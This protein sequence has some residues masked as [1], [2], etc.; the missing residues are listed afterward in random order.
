VFLIG[1]A[2]DCDLV[3]GDATFPEAYAYLLVQNEM[4]SAR[5]L[6]GGPELL[7]NGEAVETADLAAGDRLALGPFE[8]ILQIQFATKQTAETQTRTQ[9]NLL[10]S[11]GNW[12]WVADLAEV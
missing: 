7:V 5:R 9:P 6:G 2:S 1:T 10:L 8:L 4:V 11:T 3:L 12:P